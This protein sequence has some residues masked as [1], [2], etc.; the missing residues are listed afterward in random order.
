MDLLRAVR[1]AVTGA[2]G[3]PPVEDIL[4]VIGPRAA[5]RRLRRFAAAREAPPPAAA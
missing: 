1:R 5:A 2:E 4:A 3:G